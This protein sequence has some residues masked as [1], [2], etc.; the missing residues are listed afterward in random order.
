MESR[1]AIFLDGPIGAGKTTLGRALATRLGGG[2]LDGD[3]FSDPARPWYCS[4]L[5]TT[6]GIVAAGLAVLERLPVVVV[7]YPLNRLNWTVFR[8][9]FGDE[10]ARVVCVGLT[11]DPAR[12]AAPDR[13]RAFS[14]GE[15]ARMAEMINQGYGARAWADCHLRTDTAP[16]AAT[17]DRLEEE[18]GLVLKQK[19]RSSF[20]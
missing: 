7:A 11:G 8:R 4:A 12:L 5:T 18:V 10:G 6:R 19:A 15:Q 3:D 13:G 1:I 16:F 14:A 20:S 9:R 2:F 17:L